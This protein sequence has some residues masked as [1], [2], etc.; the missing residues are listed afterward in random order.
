MNLINNRSSKP[1]K[2]MQCFVLFWILLLALTATQYTHADTLRSE[3]RKNAEELNRKHSGNYE[4][5][6]RGGHYNSHRDKHW[7]KKHSGKHHGYGRSWPHKKEHW[8]K[9]RESHSIHNQRDYR[10]WLRH[11]DDRPVIWYR[12]NG[13]FLGWNPDYHR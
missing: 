12:Q 2:V 1:I 13:V 11:H 3:W 5:V 8:R 6:H 7:D 10:Q 9:H 4:K